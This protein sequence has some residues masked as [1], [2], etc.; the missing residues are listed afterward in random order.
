LGELEFVARIRN[1]V[2]VNDVIL[3]AEDR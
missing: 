3:V 2:A 1:M